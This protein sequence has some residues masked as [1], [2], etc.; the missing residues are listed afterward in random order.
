MLRISRLLVCIDLMVSIP[1]MI[2]HTDGEM[3]GTDSTMVLMLIFL[4]PLLNS[5]IRS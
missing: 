3:V 1:C 2:Q 4:K 5:S